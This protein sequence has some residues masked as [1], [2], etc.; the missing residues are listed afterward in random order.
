MI[1]ASMTSATTSSTRI[2]PEIARAARVMAATS[3]SPLVSLESIAVIDLSVAAF[4]RA[5]PKTSA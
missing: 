5:V 1:D 4:S 3:T 2:F